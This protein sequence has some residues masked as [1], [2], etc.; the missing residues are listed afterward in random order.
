[1]SHLKLKSPDQLPSHGLTLQ[2]F[3]PWK[4]H[5]RNY[6]RQDADN[7]PFFTGRIYATWRPQENHDNR[8]EALHAEDPE[9]AALQDRLQQQQN[10]AHPQYT[11]AQLNRDREALLE[12]RN[13][14]LA[15][16]ISLITMLCHYTE[17]DQ[18]DQ[19][20]TSLEWIFQFLEQKYNLSNKG[21][22]FLKIA[23]I[24]YTAGTPYDTFY[25]QLRSAIN[26]GLLHTGDTLPYRDNEVLTEDERYTPTLENVTV[27]W[28][29]Q[30][31]DP[32]LP[33]QVLK[34]FGHQLR[35][36]TRLVDIHHQVFDQI[37]ELLQDIEVAEGNRASVCNAADP[38][39]DQ[40]E[41][42]LSLNALN[43]RRPFNNF[44][45]GRNSRPQRGRGTSNQ[46][47]STNRKFCRICYVS[48]S[49]AF[50]T[51]DISTC[52]QLTQRDLEALQSRLAAF[53]IADPENLDPELIPGWDF[54]IQEEE[55]I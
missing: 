21:S 32:R 8:I 36:N 24:T 52:R 16:F 51:H 5:L 27:L 49:S 54:P 34:T 40:T 12:R 48:G 4:N 1:M 10:A 22:N 33:N 9:A 55:D 14:Q 37:P 7:A 44:G 30:L 50:N 42:D 26:D 13:A 19:R 25:K 6:L 46:R 31:I 28:A 35:G 47:Q 3:K 41:A 18:I 11:Q 2:Q 45:R 39:L 20:A 53:T 23:N 17:Q 38:P 15:K 43:T 29:L